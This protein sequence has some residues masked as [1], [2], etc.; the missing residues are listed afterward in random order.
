MKKRYGEKLKF[1]HNTAFSYKDYS[2]VGTKGF[3]EESTRLKERESFRLLSSIQSA[4]SEKLLVFFHYPPQKE[5]LDILR[6]YAVEKVI[7]AHLH[8]KHWNERIK[9]DGFKLV[10]ADYLQFK[11][12]LIVK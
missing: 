8:G 5:L 3:D 11:P 2:I 9:K 1:L 6:S 7:Y 4:K 12:K 10:S